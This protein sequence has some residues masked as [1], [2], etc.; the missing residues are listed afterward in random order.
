MRKKTLTLRIYFI[1]HSI[2]FFHVRPRC[3]MATELMT[4][5]MSKLQYSDN[6]MNIAI[7]TTYKE[8]HETS[9]NGYSEKS[10]TKT[11]K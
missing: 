4:A 11:D 9:S 3:L 5:D 8:S 10:I 2:V 1:L 7:G 6:I